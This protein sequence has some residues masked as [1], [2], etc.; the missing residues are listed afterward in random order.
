[1]QLYIQTLKT[2]R[3]YGLVLKH[4]KIITVDLLNS[5]NVHPQNVY[6]ANMV[7]MFRL[8][9]T[10]FRPTFF[11]VYGHDYR[12]A[13]LYVQAASRLVF[14]LSLCT[15][16]PRHVSCSSYHYVRAGRV[17]SRV[18]VIVMYVQTA[19][20]LVFQLS[21]CTCR[22]RHVSCS[23][24][25]VRAGCVTSRVPVMYEQ[26]ASRLVFHL[27]C[28]CRLRHV[29]CSIYHYEINSVLSHSSWHVRYAMMSLSSLH[30]GANYL[31]D[32]DVPRTHVYI[33]RVTF[34]R[35]TSLL[36]FM[37]ALLSRLF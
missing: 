4:R 27:L 34:P 24:Y 5:C 29:S 11:S 25:Y 15:C 19:S 36:C 33:N 32:F 26:A 16:R 28:T 35:F 14:Q 37:C 17:T 10:V 22:L 3:F 2:G 7:C 18:P 21:L 9:Y 30:P 23:S 20:R 13:L 8:C 6:I 31:R 12:T 1:M